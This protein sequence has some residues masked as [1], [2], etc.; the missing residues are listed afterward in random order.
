[1]SLLT[2]RLAPRIVE[3]DGAFRTRMLGIAAGRRDVIALGRGDPDFHTPPHI[4]EAAKAALD[5]NHHHYTGPTGIPALR[6]AIATNLGDR[7]GLDYG[8]DEVVV[9]AGAQEAIMLTMLGLCSPGDEVLI[10]SPRFTTYDTAVRLCGGTPVPVPTWERDDFA[11]DVA[12]IEARITPRTRM[13][14]L[15]SP[16][17]PTGAVTPPDA[18]RA[19]AE[20]AIRHDLIIVADEIYGRL[21]YAPNEHLSIATLPGMRERTVTLNGFSKAYAMTGWRVG[22]LAAPRALVEML[23]EPRHTLSINACTI[24]QHA[25][26][27]ALTGPQEPIEAMIEAYDERRH[28]L[29][30]ALTEAGYTYGHPGGAFYIYTN[31][32]STGLPAPD[33]CER[34]LRET[35]VM[36]FPGTMFGDGSTDY[37]RISYLQPLPL[38]E[39]AMDRIA[40]FTSRARSAA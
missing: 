36:L 30:P 3:E 19:I 22:Y 39:E 1:M 25:A 26:L 10:T 11:L 12:E 40:A 37:I 33:F 20:M 21:V 29:M 16:N 17:N 6:E 4:V 32:S 23:T 35:G 34:L 13:F 28:W 27:A 2:E 31:V 38:I 9:T 15:V 18:I 5:A 24:S 14:V 7:Y 8:A